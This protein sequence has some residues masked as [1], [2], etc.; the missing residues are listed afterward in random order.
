MAVSA[1]LSRAGGGIRDHKSGGGRMNKDIKKE[2]INSLHKF[3]KLTGDNG[4]S[5][6]DL[7][8][9]ENISAAFMITVLEAIM[10]DNKEEIETSGDLKL[11]MGLSFSEVILS[12]I[13]EGK[14]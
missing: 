11:I 1:G 6:I 4:V 5:D 14:E 7:R 3:M 12:C 13:R 8:I 10:D 2:V 9:R